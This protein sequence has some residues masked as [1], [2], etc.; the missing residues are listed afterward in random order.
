MSEKA[1][2]LIPAWLIY[3]ARGK[4]LPAPSAGIL[5]YPRRC[6]PI[7]VDW[8]AHIAGII[9]RL[10]WEDAW[11]GDD[12][13]KFRATQEIGKLF[14]YFLK[15]Q[16]AEMMRQKPTQPCIW[17][18]SY[19]GGETWADIFDMSLCL[20]GKSS[21]TPLEYIA[22]VNELNVEIN[23]TNDTYLG[24]V[25]NVTNNWVYGD[26]D[27]A[28][29]DAAL[30]YAIEEFIDF[31][32]ETMLKLIGDGNVEFKDGADFFAAI[33]IALAGIATG[34]FSLG[35]ATS[36]TGIGAI[37]LA[38]SAAITLVIGYTKSSDAP[39]FQDDAAKET[40]RC[41]MYLAM[42]GQ[43]PTLALWQASLSSV[44][45]P[46]TN[47]QHLN[48][49]VN[50]FLDFEDLFIQWMIAFDDVAG[51]SVPVPNACADCEALS[52]NRLD[53]DGNDDMYGVPNNTA[54]ASVYD[55]GN[56]LYIGQFVPSGGA[57]IIGTGIDFGATK[58][59]TAVRAT[60][61]IHRTASAGGTCHWSMYDSDDNP[62]ASLSNTGTQLSPYTAVMEFSG[63]VETDNIEFR[64]GI[65]TVSSTGHLKLTKLE[66]EYTV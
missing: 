58:T 53:G 31:V 30:C 13:E 6:I 60:F 29:R 5:D 22:L 17:Q 28:N 10:S 9:S 57:V 49:V 56:D 2:G 43:T 54:S 36:W 65:F 50:S 37:A 4:E 48:N 39:I 23:N 12:S 26:E 11:V 51:L 64:G 34:L 59:I 42:A 19:D 63:S 24:D 8:I 45:E 35:I 7:N 55:A 40:L 33:E 41:Q 1:L 62:I 52:Y 27:D 46:S 15:G 25:T 66:I 16:C 44:S 38:A 14:Y 3:D 18:A 21:R 47:V 61:D 32:C 20:S